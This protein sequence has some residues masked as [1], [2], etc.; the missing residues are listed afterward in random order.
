MHMPTYISNPFSH[1]QQTLMAV[2]APQE[3]VQQSHPQQ[4]DMGMKPNTHVS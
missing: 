1:S 2:P 3:R 4:Q